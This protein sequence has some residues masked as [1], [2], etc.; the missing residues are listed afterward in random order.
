MFAVVLQYL[1]SIFQREENSIGEHVGRASQSRVTQPMWG[2]GY[3]CWR[4]VR[5]RV[6]DLE[7]DDKEDRR[8]PWQGMSDPNHGEDFHAGEGPIV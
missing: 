7:Q 1:F 5:Y 8:T 4:S 3:P 6:S 2:G